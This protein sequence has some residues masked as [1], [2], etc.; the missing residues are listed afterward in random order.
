MADLQ[1]ELADGGPLISVQDRYGCRSGRRRRCG[2]RATRRKAW[3][4]RERSHSS[5]SR[6]QE[7]FT[8]LPLRPRQK[9]G[10]FFRE[11]RKSLH[12]HLPNAN[13]PHPTLVESAI[14]MQPVP[15]HILYRMPH[16]TRCL[17]ICCLGGLQRPKSKAMGCRS[18]GGGRVPPP[19]P[20]SSLLRESPH[21]Y[22]PRIRCIAATREMASM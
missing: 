19:C 12:G 13:D 8:G 4:D 9:I 11:G 18:Q 22:S 2:C 1:H 7:Q 3:A 17:V 6:S 5:D 15:R 16:N 14:Q 21:A 20:Y 10:K